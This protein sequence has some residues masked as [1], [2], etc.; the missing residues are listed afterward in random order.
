MTGTTIMP[1]PHFLGD[2][3]WPQT[4]AADP[5]REAAIASAEEHREDGLD[6]VGEMLR[7]WSAERD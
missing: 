6:I 2:T 1:E 4:G 7:A 3:T 5:L